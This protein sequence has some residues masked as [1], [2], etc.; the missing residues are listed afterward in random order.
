M[1]SVDCVQSVPSVLYRSLLLLIRVFKPIACF[2]PNVYTT[3]RI[4]T[5]GYANGSYSAPL[6]PDVLPAF[7]T[8]QDAGKLL[9]IYSS[10]SVEAQR[11]LLGHV[12]SDSGPSVDIQGLF[13]TGSQERLFDTK[14]AGMKTDRRSYEK[15]AEALGK[16]VDSLV[17]FTDNVLGEF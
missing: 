3:G 14:N 15:I 10:G 6:Y 8:I 13:K 17:F 4:W 2:S 12:A 11:L 9:A 16:G 5:S 1:P 7:Q